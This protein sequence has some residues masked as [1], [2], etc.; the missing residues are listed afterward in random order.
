MLGWLQRKMASKSTKSPLSNGDSLTR[1]R[2]FR[3]HEKLNSLRKAD[4]KYWLFGAESHRYRLGPLVGEETL[5][6]L[7]GRLSI[8]LPNEYRLYLL[9]VGNGGAGPGYGVMRFGDHI[10]PA[11]APTIFPSG[12]IADVITKPGGCQFVRPHF[13]DEN[14]RSVDPFEADYFEGIE[15]LA[16]DPSS[17][18]RPFLLQESVTSPDLKSD[19][20]GWETSHACWK[21]GSFLLAHYGCGIKAHLIVTGHERAKIWIEDLDSDLGIT[22]KPYGFLDW[23][24]RWLDESLYEIRRLYYDNR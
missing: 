18:S 4:P 6:S 1:A 14:G 10:Y 15:K 5:S 23:Y 3:I 8:D 16:K 22:R 24:E 11:R 19:D 9:N 13:V 17:I 20:A 21:D 2:I 12:D 7:E